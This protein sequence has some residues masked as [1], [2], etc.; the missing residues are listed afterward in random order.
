MGSVTH[1][2]DGKKELACDVHR[3]EKLGVRLVDSNEGGMVVQNGLESS[4]VSYV[5]V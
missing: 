3:L 5:K 1:V 2:D 4:L